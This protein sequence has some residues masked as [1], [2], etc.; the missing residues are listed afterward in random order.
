MQELRTKA[1]ELLLREQWDES[2]Q[3][4]SHFIALCEH[5]I[6]A[7]PQVADPDSSIRL[8][9][10]HKSMCLALSNRAE[11]LYR[12]RD[13][14]RA[15]GDCNKALRIEADH[16][17]TLFCKGKILL[18][19][20]RY[21][22]AMDCFKLA[23]LDGGNSKALNMYLEKCK[24][25]EYQSR[26]GTIDISE[27]VLNGFRTDQPDLAEFVGEVEIK[28]SE[29]SG[30]GLFAAKNI[31]SGTLL[32][33]TK[34]IA[35]ERGILLGDE[36][37][38]DKQLVMW[39][40]FVTRVAD[41]TSMCKR[42]SRLIGT[43]SPG[44]DEDGLE[45]PDI[46]MF[47]PETTKDEEEEEE[48]KLEMRKILSILDVNSLVEDA[49]SAK[50]LG[51]NRDYYGVGLWVLASFVN[52]SCCPNARRLHIGN[53]LIVHASREIKS[54]EE[55]TFP[56]FDVLSTLRKRNDVSV[57]NWGFSCRCKRCRH[58]AELELECR[59][60]EASLD[61]GGF[62]YR[63]EE[64]MRR[65][66]VRGKEKGYL[67]ASFWSVYSGTYSSEKEMKRWGRRIPSL[68]V[69]VD[70]VVESVG[71]DER[72][73]KVLVEQV[74]KNGVGIVEM[75]KVLKLGRGLY[76]KV[77]KKQALRSLLEIR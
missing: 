33:V 38:Q 23:L 65:W 75:E 34:A 45:V 63:L 70:S 14:N 52:H 6:S 58:E 29:L 40:D 36:L 9:K 1:N 17:K 11:A 77:V 74:K 60:I 12:L 16:F 5:Q 64:G 25:L 21:A 43:L 47:R 8:S 35:L 22:L 44:E 67:R 39:K 73:V 66:G 56:Y 3:L 28:K 55:I 26:T 46:S 68:E 42:T 53:H 49:T 50:V 27:W 19:L 41:S 71:S 31:E 20:N 76:G 69:V 7:I 72:V 4:Y 13:L 48:E 59:S 37:G 30:R 61:T 62:V 10:L 54:G 32:L 24:K 15:L 18:S 57:A 2:L 51:R